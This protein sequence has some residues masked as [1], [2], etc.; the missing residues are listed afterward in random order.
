MMGV[1][2]LG[3]RPLMFQKEGGRERGEGEKKVVR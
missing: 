1:M 3:T 2:A